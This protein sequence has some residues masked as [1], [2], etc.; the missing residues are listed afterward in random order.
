M[1]GKLLLAGQNPS[2]G[3]KEKIL[4][5]LS[6]LKYPGAFPAFSMRT[7]SD[8]SILV[9]LSRKLHLIYCLLSLS[10]TCVILART[11]NS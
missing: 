8:V 7:Y 4:E 10:K 6:H 11:S 2:L 1:I 5:E 9:E 3:E